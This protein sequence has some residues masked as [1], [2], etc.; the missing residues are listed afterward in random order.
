M[1]REER[2]DP[3]LLD[4]EDPLVD[5]ELAVGVDV[6][7]REHP[8]EPRPLRRQRRDGAQPLDVAERAGGARE[9]AE[10][11]GEFLLVERAVV[12]VVNEHHQPRCG[13]E[14]AEQRRQRRGVV[15]V[16]R[17]RLLH[18]AVEVDVAHGLDERAGALVDVDG[19]RLVEV[20]EIE[21]LLQLLLVQ[22]G[23]R[24][25]RA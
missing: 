25:Q 13:G 14:G 6:G 8:V 16:D 11:V 17:R 20:D 10:A 3:E 21:E 24:P 18:R 19:A 23:R 12:V 1:L 7:L 5:V 15:H 22:V 4:E 9:E 2:R